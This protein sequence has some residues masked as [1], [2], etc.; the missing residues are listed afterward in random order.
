M[1]KLQYVDVGSRIARIP[2]LHADSSSL[3]GEDLPR[4]QILKERFPVAR[5]SCFELQTAAEAAEAISVPLC[6][7]GRASADKLCLP[8]RSCMYGVVQ[9]CRA[10]LEGSTGSRRTYLSRRV[11]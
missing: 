11:F 5:L 6:H 1:S 2:G 9:I 3:M 4:R 8:S 10:N 7:T